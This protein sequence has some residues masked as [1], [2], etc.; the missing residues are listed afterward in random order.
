MFNRLAAIAA[1]VGLCAIVGA[2]TVQNIMLDPPKGEGPEDAAYLKAAMATP[3]TFTVPAEKSE[4]TWSRINSFISKH[5][6]MK[7]QTASDYIIE[8]YN[9]G[10]GQFAYSANRAT[11]GDA[12][13]FTVACVSGG[14]IV[15][16][17]KGFA[18]QEKQAE[19]NAH[20]LAYFAVTGEVRETLVVK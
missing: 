9:P 5:S 17:F 15:L 7:I 18:H 8:T 13:E 10:A 11:R 4:E 20:L 2:C 16:Y 3:L 12:A 14:P 1:C 19:H 6:S